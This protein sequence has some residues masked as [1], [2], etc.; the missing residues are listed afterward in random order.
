MSIPVHLGV[1]RVFDDR[2]DLFARSADGVPVT[3]RLSRAAATS[4]GLALF[5]VLE[6]QAEPRVDIPATLDHPET[7]PAAEPRAPP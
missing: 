7:L 1:S 2:I 5:R 3:L 4:L 6:G